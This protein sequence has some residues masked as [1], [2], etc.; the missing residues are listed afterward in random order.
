MAARNRT[1]ASKNRICRKPVVLLLAQR[2]KT[3]R[4][5]TD[6]NQTTYPPLKLDNIP[7]GSISFGCRDSRE[8][9][10]IVDE[11]PHRH[12]SEMATV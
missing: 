8:V 4:C 7:V 10:L 11:I 9:L 6:S 1:K 12:K 2:W 3:Q 5:S